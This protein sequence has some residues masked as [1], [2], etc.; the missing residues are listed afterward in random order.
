MSERRSA[1][2]MC[3]DLHDAARRFEVGSEWMHYLGDV[4]EITGHGVDEATGEVEVRY[5]R[6][7]PLSDGRPMI[8]TTRLGDFPPEYIR[9]IEFHRPLASFA[10]MV[11]G[12]DD[13][14]FRPVRRCEHFEEGA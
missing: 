6:S 5:R 11:E 2:E 3:R 4:Y 14:R 12:S 1:S 10:G 9:Q 13:R 7:A 8:R